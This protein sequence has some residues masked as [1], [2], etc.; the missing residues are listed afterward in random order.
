MCNV[1][2]AAIDA[3]F[4]RDGNQ[5]RSA[6]DDETKYHNAILAR[7]AFRRNF[8]MMR[9]LGSAAKRA[10]RGA[11]SRKRLGWYFVRGTFELGATDSEASTA[12]QGKRLHGR[13]I[14][15]LKCCIIDAGQLKNSVAIDIHF[16]MYAPN[17]IIFIRQYD[18]VVVVRADAEQA[19]D[20]DIFHLTVQMSDGER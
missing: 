3:V 19:P 6:I 8:E 14:A 5:L 1:A 4:V 7:R 16:R 18:L 2:L 9:Q 15:D 12:K 10:A 11:R 20:V 13:A 17:G